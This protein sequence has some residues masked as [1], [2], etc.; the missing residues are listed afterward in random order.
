MTDTNEAAQRRSA[1]AKGRRDAAG[2]S[3]RSQHPQQRSATP[4]DRAT[5]APPMTCADLD[6]LLAE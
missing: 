6:R 4:H 1:A 3:D 2:Y 5:A